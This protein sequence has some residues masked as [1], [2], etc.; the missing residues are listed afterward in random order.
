MIKEESNQIKKISKKTK[1]RLL[2]KA[3]WLSNENTCSKHSPITTSSAAASEYIVSSSS[4]V[5]VIPV[6]KLRAATCVSSNCSSR[7]KKTIDEEQEIREVARWRARV[8]EPGTRTHIVRQHLLG[9]C[10]RS[11]DLQISGEKCSDQSCTQRLNL[12]T[13]KRRGVVHAQ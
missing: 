11:T 6:S 13:L 5:D 4:P 1:D 9:Q 8:Q 2:I 7:T 3:I 12:L 10:S